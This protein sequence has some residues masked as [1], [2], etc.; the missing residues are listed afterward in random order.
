MT[1][2]KC[3]RHLAAPRA[4]G[5]KNSQKSGKERNMRESTGRAYGE[6]SMFRPFPHVPPS[7]LSNY[8]QIKDRVFVARRHWR[9]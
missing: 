2:G 5:L 9:V 6:F 4:I 3:Q 8:N 1:N 7:P